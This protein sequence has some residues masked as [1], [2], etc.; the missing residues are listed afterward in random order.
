M[1]SWETFTAKNAKNAKALLGRMDE[2][3][4]AFHQWLRVEV[5]E[6]PG[7]DTGKFQVG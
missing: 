6:E 7:L 1:S 2:S 5:H 3:L 4:D